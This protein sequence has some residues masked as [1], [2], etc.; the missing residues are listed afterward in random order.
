MPGRKYNAGSGY[1]YG[2]NGKEKAD[3]IT[4]D[5]YDFGARIY[6]GRIGRWMSVDDKDKKYPSWSPYNYA[7]DNPVMVID[8]DG[9]DIILLTWATKKGSY[10]HTAIAIQNYIGVK[11]KGKWIQKP[12]N[13]YTIYEIGPAENLYSP[14]QSVTS[15][16]PTHNNITKEQLLSNKNSNGIGITDWD[17]GIAP[18]GMIEFKTDYT[19]DKVAT[20]KMEYKVESNT[21]YYSPIKENSVNANCTNY[22]MDIIPIANGDKINATESVEW[23]GKNYS[24]TTPNK[25][26]NEASNLKGAN[27]LKKIP[28]EI[29]NKNFSDAFYDITRPVPLA[30]GGVA[31]G[32]AESIGKNKGTK[33]D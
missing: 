32:I 3:E 17:K 16:T 5:G 2:F 18:D 26:Y 25:L 15:L 21:L 12:T 33:L 20:Q 14:L 24:T 8:P 7:I 22:C 1:R 27:I 6:D 29:A 30:V 11:E 28:A 10:G 9:E 4:S 13:T 23:E 31:A 19:Y